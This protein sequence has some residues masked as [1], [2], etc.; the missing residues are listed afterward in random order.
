MEMYRTRMTIVGNC[1]DHHAD[2]SAPAVGMLDTKIRLN[3]VISDAKN[4]ARYSCGDI[5]DYYLN[6]ELKV[7]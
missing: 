4:G 7:F 1:L 5:K 2:T 3:S 6:N